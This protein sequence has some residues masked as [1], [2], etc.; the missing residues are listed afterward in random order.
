MCDALVWSVDVLTGLPWLEI[1]KA[2]APVATAFVAFF[3]LKNWQRQDKAKRQADFLDQLTEAV[4]TFIAEMSKPLTLAQFIKT[5]ME[6]HAPTWE[7]G[8]Q[9]KK[10]VIAY[11]EKRGE[12]DSK[13]LLKALETVQ[14]TTIRLRSLVAKGQVFR[15]KGYT[16]C[17]DAVAM[18]TWQFDRLEALMAFIGSP[19]WNWEHPEVSSL[20][21]K[22]A[23]NTD[24]VQK[25]LK[26]NNVA[27]IEFVTA[28]YGHMYD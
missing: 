7:G 1:I 22:M 13:R 3:A 27:I 4:H 17:Q 26:D 28:T 20:L 14:P 23:I 15:L 9:S 12:E 8:D 18:L 11:I 6:S 2:A 16:Q 5:N 21:A 19:S 24:E 10:G 25:S